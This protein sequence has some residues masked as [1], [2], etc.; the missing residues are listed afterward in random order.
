MLIGI[1]AAIS[2]GVNSFQMSIQEAGFDNVCDE[3]KAEIRK[4]FLTV[5]NQA[6]Q[7]ALSEATAKC[8]AHQIEGASF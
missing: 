2:T 1:Q 8:I 6:L 5:T 7:E 3:A 4:S